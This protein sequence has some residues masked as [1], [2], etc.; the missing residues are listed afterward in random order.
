[1]AYVVGF[2]FSGGKVQEVSKKEPNQEYQLYTDKKTLV[3]AHNRNKVE[4]KRDNHFRYGK[5]IYFYS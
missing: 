4:V 5:E 2:M 1:M 3:K